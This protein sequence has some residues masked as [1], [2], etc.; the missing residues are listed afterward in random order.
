MLPH[1]LQLDN[2]ALP[3]APFVG[4]SSESRECREEGIRGH[5]EAEHR[6]SAGDFD[7]D[8]PAFELGPDRHADEKDLSWHAGGLKDSGPSTVIPLP[9]VKG[10]NTRPASCGPCVAAISAPLSIA[11]GEASADV[12][13]LFPRAA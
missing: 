7:R 2:F 4:D 5:L 12:S 11:A 9:K 1:N 10:V 13:P 3:S 8:V 6:R